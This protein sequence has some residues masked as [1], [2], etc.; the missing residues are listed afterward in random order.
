M[1][2]AEDAIVAAMRAAEEGV[3]RAVSASTVPSGGGPA[4]WMEAAQREVDAA[5]AAAAS[6][7]SSAANAEQAAQDAVNQAMAAAE[8]ALAGLMPGA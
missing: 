5:M 3:Q 7:T 8:Q 1:Q 4:S 2:A 6:A